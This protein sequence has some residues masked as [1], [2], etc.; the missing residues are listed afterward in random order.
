MYMYI[1]ILPYEHTLGS[2]AAASVKLRTSDTS[3]LI[4]Y[5]ILADYTPAD[6][7]A[8]AVDEALVVEVVL[9]KHHLRVRP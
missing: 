1:R 6:D 2:A 3:T 9:C 8:A 4:S 5:H 7:A